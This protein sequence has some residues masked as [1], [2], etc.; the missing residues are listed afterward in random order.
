MK[1]G[2]KHII[3]KQIAGVLVAASERSPREQVFLV[4][5]DGSSFEFWGDDFNCGAG[6]DR[7]DGIWRYVTS[8]KGEI[9]RAY[10]RPGDSARSGR[11]PLTTGRE[12]PPYQVTAPETL[13]GLMTRDLEAWRQAKA[14]ITKARKPR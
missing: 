7:S 6:L 2:L 10:G 11:P 12:R 13:E 9:V 5:A 8:G 3:G 4:F 14:V 1:G